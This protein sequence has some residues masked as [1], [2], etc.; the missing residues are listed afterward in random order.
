MIRV[1]QFEGV[2]NQFLIETE[3]GDLFQSYDSAIALIDRNGKV[4]LSSHWDYS[5]TTGK[6]RNR[7][8]GE[9][10]AETRARIA[11]GEYALDLNLDG[12]LE[13]A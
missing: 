1:S 6:Y 7:F 2:K 13:V 3:S 10:I 4:H 9:G 5:N 8:L 12:S 11:S